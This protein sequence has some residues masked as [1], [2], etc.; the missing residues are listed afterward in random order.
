MSYIAA[1]FIPCL[2]LFLKG[3]IGTAIALLIAQ[4]TI[5]GWFFAVP[6]AWAVVHEENQKKVIRKE[7][8]RDR[9]INS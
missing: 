7:F 5:I 9:A 1:L 6:V 8:R 4:I 3:R 2:P